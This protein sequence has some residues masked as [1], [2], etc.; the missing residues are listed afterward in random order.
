MRDIGI[1]NW[2]GYRIPISER[3]ALIKAAGF[4]HVM[5]WWGDEYLE[6]D[7]PKEAHPALFR[8]AGLEIASVHLPFAGVNNL[9]L[10][11]ADGERIFH[12]LLNCLEGCAKYQLPVAVLHVSSG[13]APPPFS[14][15]GIRRFQALADLAASSGIWL[16]LENLQR[17]EYLDYVFA[18]VESDALAFCYDSGHDLLYASASY[19]M[20]DMY[21]DKLKAV[22]LHDNEGVFDDHLLPG[23]GR[24]EWPLVKAKLDKYYIGPYMLECDN[25]GKDVEATSPAEYLAQA[26]AAAKRLLAT[27]RGC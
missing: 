23:Q 17:L 16:A 19:L 20:I 10:D 15:V 3:A 24:V 9:W 8:N 26:F 18:R 6:Y 12:Y 21:G 5:L 11:N 25:F 13:S 14:D 22:H 27:D 4:S 1:F 2:F 7:S